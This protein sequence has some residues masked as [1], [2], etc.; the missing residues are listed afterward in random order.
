ML[1]VP[2]DLGAATSDILENRLSE[3]ESRLL[4]VAT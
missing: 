4:S 2:G 1:N 3:S